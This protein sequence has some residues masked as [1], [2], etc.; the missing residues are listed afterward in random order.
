MRSVAPTASGVSR[1]R[2]ARTGAPARASTALIPTVR[3]KVL[4][5]DM[6]EPLTIKTR[7][8]PPSA[9][10]LRTQTA[11]W[12]SGWPT[13]SASKHAGPSTSSGNGSA[14]FSAA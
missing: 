6:F 10:S 5:P 8:T 9:T 7:V 11:G 14:G 2:E 1:S 12:I 3:N 4:L 13:A